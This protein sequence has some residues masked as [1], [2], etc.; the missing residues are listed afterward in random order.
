MK[1][2]LTK[3]SGYCKYMT[4]SNHLNYVNFRICSHIYM[5]IVNF[6]LYTYMQCI[7]TCVYM[8]MPQY[9]IRIRTKYCIM[10]FYVQFKPKSKVINK[11]NVCN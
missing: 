2:L 6:N 4:R 7:L 11:I 5:F 3:F 9:H 8:Y 10:I 1:L